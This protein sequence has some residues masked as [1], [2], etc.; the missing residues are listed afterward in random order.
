[1][2]D[3]ARTYPHGVSCWVDTEQPDPTAASVFYG[4]LF[5]WT[6]SNAMPPGAPAQ[7]LIAQLDGGDVAA[8]GTGHDTAVWNTY[9]AATDAD[10]TADTVLANGG[11][12][13]S[14][15]ADAGP[16]GRAATCRDPQGAE[17]RLWQPYKRLGAQVVNVPGSWNFSDLRTTDAQAASVFYASLFGWKYPDLGPG[18]ESMIS[19]PGYGD[20]LAA[21]VD[22]DI[23][24]RQAEVP[25][26]FADVIGAVQPAAA[27]EPAHWQVTFAVADR[28]SIAELAEKLGGTVLGTSE[29][30]WAVTANLRDPQ[31]AEFTLSEFRPPE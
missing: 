7:Y 19:V 14:P 31:G 18:V 30:E 9:F 3:I 11:T 26:G 13:V 23:Y 20:H 12:V 4:E 24:V 28:D 2:P 15:P 6:F 21:T 27:S 22:P 8:I 25:A 5:G 29:Y 16:G 10:Q 1:M 17:F